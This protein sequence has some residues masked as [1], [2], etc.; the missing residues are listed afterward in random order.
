MV[1]EGENK[2]LTSTKFSSLRMKQSISWLKRMRPNIDG[3]S[4]LINCSMRRRGHNLSVG[5]K[6]LTLERH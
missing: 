4:I 2:D 1:R 6:N 5:S 3:E